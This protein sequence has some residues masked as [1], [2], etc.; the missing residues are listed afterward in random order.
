MMKSLFIL[1]KEY[2]K[3]SEIV[4]TVRTKRYGESLFKMGVTK[5]AYKIINSNDF[6]DKNFIDLRINNHLI[7]R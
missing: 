2:E 6:K 1:I 4:H 5:I 7:I 3:G